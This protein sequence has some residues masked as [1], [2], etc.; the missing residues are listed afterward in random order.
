MLITQRFG[1]VMGQSA[2]TSKPGQQR[3]VLAAALLAMSLVGAPPAHAD[4]IPIVR[5]AETEALVYDY[6][7]PIFKVA[8]VTQPPTVHVVQSDQFN[9]FVTGR[10]DLFVNTETIIETNTPNELTGILAHE[11][12]H[13][14]N[15]DVAHF[16]QQLAETK[17]AL[18]VATLLGA[19]VAAA[20]AVTSNT[21][22]SQAGVGVISAGG[23]IAE[24]SL[25]TFR[26]DQEAAADRNGVK[27][28]TAT[29]Q[30]SSGMLAVLKR[31]A[32]QELLQSSQINPYM[33][34]HPLSRE[35][36]TA[37]Q[38]LVSGS[39]F[40]SVKDPPEL[41]R[42]H[43]LVRAKLIGFTWPSLR[44]LRQ[45]PMSDNSLPARYARAIVA[46][47][48]GKPGPAQ[49]L[50][51]DL[52]R[53]DPADPYFYELKGQALLEDG[54]VDSA[55]PP[56][57]KAVGLAPNASLIKI[58]LG[59]ALVAGGDAGKAPEAIKLLTSAMQADPDMGVGYRA[60][61][62]AYALTGNEPMAQLATAQGLFAEG[63]YD[64]ARIQATRAQAKLK[65]G[66]PAW[67]R[68]DDIVSYKVPK[69]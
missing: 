47:R 13:I 26:R 53:S 9:A 40:L 69:H 68:A 11:T 64:N 32:N 10:N 60:L 37:L 41:Q 59:Q 31:L 44:V 66:T 50:I 49:Q 21:Q 55:L 56:L 12:G 7:R 46:Y 28:L 58:L 18:L 19:G 2:V 52:I 62:R 6:L 27:F 39:Q 48:S 29:G 25:L 35:R 23:N 16:Q 17:G 8:G 33:Q 14:V 3:R 34:T 61:G 54:K 5:D 20:G 57:R 38:D 22:A 24:R 51:D 43:D 45:Y 4:G 36:V 67:L 42:R 1:E 15:D 65:P 63:D 30:S